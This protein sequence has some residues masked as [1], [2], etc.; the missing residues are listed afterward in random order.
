[1]SDAQ[2]YLRDGR[3]FIFASSCST[4][5]FLFASGALQTLD[6]NKDSKLI[7]HAVLAALA[8]SHSDMPAPK[9]PKSITKPLLK[10]SGVKSWTSFAKGAKYISVSCDDDGWH[11]TPTQNLGV[12]D[13]F[14]DLEQK[15]IHI[16]RKMTDRQIGEAVIRALEIST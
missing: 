9:D 1:M 14:E 13:G 2:I 7:G 5:G 15:E 10:A 16:K 8:E 4:S 3:L 12:K 6:A 11:F